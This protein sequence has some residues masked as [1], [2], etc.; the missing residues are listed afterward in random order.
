MR[1]SP[2]EDSRKSQSEL[3]AK[4]FDFPTNEAPAA[5]A[6]AILQELRHDD[7]NVEVAWSNGRRRV[8]RSYPQPAETLPRRPIESGSVWVVSGGARGIT[9][10]TAMELGKRYG[11]K[12]HLLG[13]TPAPKSASSA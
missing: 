6:D 1:T 11:L 3:R 4:V 5:I 2:V 12:L 10:T 8:V 9:A 13:R 7:P